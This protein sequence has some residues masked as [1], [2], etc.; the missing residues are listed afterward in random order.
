MK[1][2]VAGGT[3]VLG[4]HIVE[5]ARRA[6]HDVSALS[7]R[8]GSDLVTGEGLDAAL[9]GVEVIVD[10]TN[11]TS[12][13]KGRATTFFTTVTRNLQ[14]HGSRAGVE[15]LLT[16]S[17]VNIERVPSG[18]YRAKL[19]QEGAAR[20]GPLPVSIV[21]ATQFHEFPAQILDRFHLGPI[22]FMPRMQVQTV[23]ARALSEVVVDVAARVPTTINV[24]GP[25]PADLVDLARAVIARRGGKQR[26]I[27]MPIP[28]R[29]GSAMRSGALLPPEDARLVGPT[30]EEWL[31]GEDVFAIGR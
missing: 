29:A 27:A 18:Y 19:A 12:Q 4:Q 15:R 7:R 10:A 26:L 28:G 30:F 3:G 6:G 31:A 21:R 5:A 8:N 14:T 23:A 11:T 25:Q 20:Q 2:A 22:A 13:A 9:A 24:A 16:I 17:I 1:I